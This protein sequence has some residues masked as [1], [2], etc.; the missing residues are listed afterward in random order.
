MAGGDIIILRG[1]R[2]FVVIDSRKEPSITFT[3]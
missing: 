1:Q 3:Y 2:N